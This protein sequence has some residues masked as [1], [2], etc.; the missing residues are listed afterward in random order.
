MEYM[1]LDKLG[2]KVSR[3]GFGCMR[4]P[5]TAEGT[6]DEARAE[7]ML[8]TAYKAGVNYFDT[9][10]FYHNRTSEE[11]VGRMLKKYPRESFYLATKLPLS[12]IENFEQAKEIFEGQFATMQVEY[13]DFYL[14]HCINEKNWKTTLDN[15]LIDYLVE[16]KKQGKIRY[17][18]FS[19]HDKYELF[20]EVMNAYDW[21]FCQIQLNYMDTKIQAGMKGYQ[22]ATD[23]GIP[24]IVMEPVKGGSLATLSE[25]IVKVFKDAHPDWS[26]ASWAMRWAANLDNCKVILSGMSSEEQVADNLST[27][28]ATTHLSEDDMQTIGKVRRMIEERTFVGC[29]D[30]KYCMPCPFGVD[31]PRNFAMM[32]NFAKYSNEG[33]LAF[34]WK[35]M[36]EDAHADK[37]KNCG[38][39]ETACPQALPIREKLH[40]IAA[41]MNA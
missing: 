13:F 2:A 16:Q 31:I 11:F 12:L 14:L 21:D 36:G 19:F 18:G 28:A 29:T 35:D 34:R 3:L 10:Y 22:L 17:L 26:V 39:C 15:Q 32:N 23:R 1:N 30:C 5:L 33:D 4:F 9:A 27:F 20:E 40:E 38:K 6:I 8:D 7:A 41:R 24:V 37:C 25:D